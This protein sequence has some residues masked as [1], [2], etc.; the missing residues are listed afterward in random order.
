VN[1]QADKRESMRKETGKRKSIYTGKL[2]KRGSI[3][4][5]PGK[6]EKHV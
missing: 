6:K 4:R 2:V 1:R 5:Q 3:H